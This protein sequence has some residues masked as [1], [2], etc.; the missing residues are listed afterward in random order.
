M[1][2]TFTV[3]TDKVDMGS[4]EWLEDYLIGILRLQ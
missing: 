3:R 2:A 1:G 4:V